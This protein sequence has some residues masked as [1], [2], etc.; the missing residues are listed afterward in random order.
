MI[1]LLKF[2]VL[3]TSEKDIDE[4]FTKLG[5][6]CLENCYIAYDEKSITDFID[7][8]ILKGEDT[9]KEQRE[10][11]AKEVVMYNYPNAS[12]KIIEYIKKEMEL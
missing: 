12:D 3:F 5:K 4:K 10:K 7:N 2:V 6:K 8:V 1:L 9:K 11:V